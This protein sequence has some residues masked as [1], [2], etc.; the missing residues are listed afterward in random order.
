MK[1]PNPK[2]ITRFEH[3]IQSTLSRNDA[4]ATWE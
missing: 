2:L 1:A 4:K 3:N